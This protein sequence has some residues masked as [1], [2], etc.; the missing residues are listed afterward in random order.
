[1][2]KCFDQQRVSAARIMVVGCGALGNEVLK[3]LVLLGVEHIVV[4]DFDVVEAGNLS[5]SILFSKSDSAQHRLK[6]EVVA[7]RLRA[8]NPAV[9]IV[10]VCGDIAYDVGL[11]L[12]RRQDVVIGCVDSRWARYCIN[13][14]CMRAGIPWVDGGIGELEGTSRVFVPGKNCYA[15]NLGPKGLEELAKRMPCAGVIRRHEE[16]GEMPTTSIVASV[17]GAVQVQEALK[18]IHGDMLA[19]GEHTSLC[20]KMFYY[21]GQHLTTK[22]V[23]FQAYDDDCAVHD[24][25]QPIR[26]SSITSD[27]TISEVLVTIE[28]ELKVKD[29]CICLENDCFVDY[30]VDRSTDHRVFVMSPG[31]LVEKC[32]DD[33]LLL[34]GVPYGSLYQHEFREIDSNFPY[35]DSTLSQ[36]GIPA[37][38]VL[39]VV[40]EGSEYYMEMKEQ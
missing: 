30:V 24:Q 26:P 12:L 31:H 18:L 1:M 14:L 38:D 8:I 17:I 11:G 9:E 16:I 10:T 3:N 39:H 2:G 37:W 23:D 25:W 33:N 27:M 20:G 40:A 36:L 4:V 34:A 29:A 5:R 13:R 28:K 19:K 32:I 6:V 35:M 7:E 15:C 22:L 21:D